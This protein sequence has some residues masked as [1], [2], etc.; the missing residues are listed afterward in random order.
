MHA[1][2]SHLGQLR[3]SFRWIAEQLNAEAQFSR[4]VTRNGEVRRD[5]SEQLDRL[6][7]Q[8]SDPSLLREPVD[9]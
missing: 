5:S 6:L 2:P 7:R 1:D 4:P 8:A 9:G 3:S